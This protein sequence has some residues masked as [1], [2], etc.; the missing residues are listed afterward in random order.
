MEEDW[1]EK[2][3]PK[4]LKDVVGN[5]KAV[6]ALSKWAEEWKVSIPKKRAVILDGSPGVG[7]TSAALALANDMDW[8]VIELNASDVR[9]EEA[10]SKT[11]TLGA[12]NETFTSEGDFIFTSQGGKKL[13]ILDEA[14]SLYER[15]KGGND[16]GGKKAIIQT[17]LGTSQPIVLIVNDYY[18]LTKG[19]GARLKSL[20][21]KIT[22]LSIRKPTIRHTLR[23][24]A[25]NEGID[26]GKEALDIIS[27]RARGDL[28]SAI[29]DLQSLSIGKNALSVEDVRALGYRDRTKQIF[30]TVRTILKTSSYQSAREATW[31]LDESPDFLL[32]WLEENL[33]LEYKDPMDRARGFTA[34]ARADWYLSMASRKNHYSLWS[35]ANDMMTGGIAL[36]K[37]NKNRSFVRYGFP[38]WLRGMSS[39]KASRGLR[40]SLCSKIGSY[41][42]MSQQTVTEDMVPWFKYLFQ[43]DEELRA[44]MIVKMELEPEEVASLLDDEKDSQTVVRAMSEA[45]VLEEKGMVKVKPKAAQDLFRF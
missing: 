2:Y 21:Q 24:I 42:H 14:D 32:L 23:F 43:N 15:A 16:R 11:A 35:Y 20:C 5:Q 22:F 6:G 25:Q 17:I 10:I 8:G 31:D 45:K 40:K 41:C 27:E 30:D 13:I 36:A 29:K 7:K 19:T 28:R 12:L 39:S 18:A 44:R 4:G 37:H 9:N 33:P 3:R 38:S 34:L 1:T 26:V